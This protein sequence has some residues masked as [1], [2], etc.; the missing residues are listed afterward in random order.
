MR[1]SWSPGAGSVRQRRTAVESGPCADGRRGSTVIN[2]L[3]T[4][5]CTQGVSTIKQLV[6]VSHPQNGPRQK[7]GSVE[8]CSIESMFEK[9]LWADLSPRFAEVD[10]AGV[11]AAVA[12]AARTQNAMCA[13]E[14]SAI[15]E[16]YARRAPEDDVDRSNWAID[17]YDNVVAEISAA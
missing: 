10:D 12:A 8:C 15:G 16:L 9:A 14:L 13:R 3:V 11:V 1:V 6:S 17:G 2:G 5:V 4:L 7:H